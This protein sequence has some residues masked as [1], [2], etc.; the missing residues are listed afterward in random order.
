MLSSENSCSLGVPGG[1][2]VDAV[3]S[4]LPHLAEPA[5]AE[6]GSSAKVRMCKCNREAE[7][8]FYPRGGHTKPSQNTPPLDRAPQQKG[9]T[10]SL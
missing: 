10:P 4:P 9:V 2:C 7:K 1:G 6:Q 5:A 3:A 8:G